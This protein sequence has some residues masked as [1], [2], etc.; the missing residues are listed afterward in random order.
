MNVH[1]DKLCPRVTNGPRTIQSSTGSPTHI[2]ETSQANQDGWSPFQKKKIY[3][4]LKYTD[5]R[6]QNECFPSIYPKNQISSQIFLL[7]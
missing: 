6:D 4:N 2:R 1:T 5:N 3:F 7:F